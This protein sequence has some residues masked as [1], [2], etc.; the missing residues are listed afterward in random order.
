MTDDFL[1]DTI[2]SFDIHLQSRGRY[3][4]TIESY[5]TPTRR[6]YAWLPE[7]GEAGL[8]AVTRK[9]I[10][11]Y[12]ATGLRPVRGTGVL[13]PAS[14][15][16]HFKGLQ[17]FWRWYSELEEIPDPMLRMHAPAVPEVQKDIVAVGQV[18]GVLLYLDAKKLYRDAALISLL[19]ENGLRISEAVSL[20]WDEIDLRNMQATVR[21]SK[22]HEPRV[23]PFGPQTAKRLDVLRRKARVD[24]WVFPG[25]EGKPYTRFAAHSM[26]TRRFRMFGMEGVGPHDLR[27]SMATAFMDENPDGEATLM[28]VGGWRSVNMVRRYSKQ[29]RDRRAIEDF[30][31]RS[32]T[33]RL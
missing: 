26:V 19:M 4:R 12:L 11:R 17:Q 9:D 3:P 5:I 18:R 32:P 10:E 23:V 28:T 24:E 22:N 13:S 14:R 31:K 27:H 30:R 7:K 1:N 16:Y 33:G 8:K 15:S 2:A 21:S 6:F 25:K 20:R 29:G